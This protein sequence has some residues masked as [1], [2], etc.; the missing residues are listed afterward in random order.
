MIDA[1]N[2]KYLRMIGDPL[3]YV[4]SEIYFDTARATR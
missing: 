1:I 2:I 3:S 4:D